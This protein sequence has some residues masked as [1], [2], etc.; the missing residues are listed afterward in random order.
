MI[1]LPGSMLKFHDSTGGAALEWFEDVLK[2]RVVRRKSKLVFTRTTQFREVN[3]KNGEVYIA[4]GDP[5]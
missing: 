5:K 1:R 3:R 4:I 2:G